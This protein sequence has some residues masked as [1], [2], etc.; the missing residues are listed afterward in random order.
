M[1]DVF[2]SSQFTFPY[3]EFKFPGQASDE[4]ILYITREAPVMF[5]LRFLFVSLAAVTIVIVSWFLTGLAQGLFTQNLWWVRLAGAGAG[6]LFWVVGS[7]WVYS[8]WK[9]SMFI[10]TNRRLTKFIYVTPLNRY[11]LSVTHDKV[12]DTGAYSRGYFEAL[13]KIGTLTARSSA[14]N[15]PE[16]Y[17]YVENIS[18]AEDLTNYINKLLFIFKQDVG[19]LDTF[20]PFIAELKGDERKQFMQKFPEYWS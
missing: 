10:L 7:W 11:N 17:F 6:F 15:R 12:D 5:Y 18:A 19:K 16:K 14:S 2:S 4:R 13:F 8:L 9:K 20:R 3:T 1:R